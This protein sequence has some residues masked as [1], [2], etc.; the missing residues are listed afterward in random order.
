MNRA[1]ISEL[2]RLYREIELGMKLPAYDGRKSLYTAGYLPFDAKEF[3]VKLVEEDGRI[4]I[5][6]SVAIMLFSL[7]SCFLFLYVCLQLFCKGA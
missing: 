1:I 2:V 5:A 3:V 4:G 6:R 7:S